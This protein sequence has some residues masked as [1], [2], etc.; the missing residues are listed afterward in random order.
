MPL[1]YDKFDAVSAPEVNCL[2]DQLRALD[3]TE[4]AALFRVSPTTI[5]NWKKT[6]ISRNSQIYI[7][8]FMA[9]NDALIES[10]VQG[11]LESLA[12][13]QPDVLKTPLKRRCVVLSP[14]WGEIRRCDG[15]RMD[16]RGLCATHKRHADMGMGFLTVHGS[17]IGVEGGKIRRNTPLPRQCSFTIRNG[18]RCPVFSFDGTGVCQAHRKEIQ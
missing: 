11:F 10:G 4:I 14:D 1:R 3:N 12:E 6:G 8:T 17:I 7:T 5:Y 16:S 15:R 9:I 2:F 13:F 18:S